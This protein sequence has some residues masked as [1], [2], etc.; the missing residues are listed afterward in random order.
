MLPRFIAPRGPIVLNG[1]KLKRAMMYFLSGKLFTVM[2]QL[3]GKEVIMEVDTEAS[4]SVMFS[5]LPKSLFPRAL[6][7][8]AARFRTYMAKE[9]PVM[10]QMS[11]DIRYGSFSGKYT[12]YVVTGD[13]PCIL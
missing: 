9:M 8:T 12:L 1:L 6:L 10:G 2:M 13:G 7:R 4:V 5:K 3:D 11:V